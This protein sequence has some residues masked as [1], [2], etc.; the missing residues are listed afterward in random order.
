MVWAAIFLLCTPNDC[1][2]AGSPLFKSKEECEYS[3]VAHGLGL[4]NDRFPHHVLMAWMCVSF[5][6]VITHGDVAVDRII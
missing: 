3:T 2:T 6:K 5:G 4:V 1:M